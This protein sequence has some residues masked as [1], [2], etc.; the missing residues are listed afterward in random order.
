MNL[1]TLSHK[2]KYLYCL[3]LLYR[4]HYINTTTTC[5]IF[6]AVSWRCFNSKL[7]KTVW[8]IK[9]RAATQTP[10]ILN[11]FHIA[12]HIQEHTHT[13]TVCL[14]PP[15]QHTVCAVQAGDNVPEVF[16]GQ[17][18][19]SE[20]SDFRGKLQRAGADSLHVLHLP[21]IKEPRALWLSLLDV[22]SHSLP[23]DRLSV[24]LSA[25]ARSKRLP[26]YLFPLNFQFS[27]KTCS[28]LQNLA[29][30]LW[31]LVWKCKV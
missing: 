16:Q 1:S 5:R 22:R 7:I 13:N 15:P 21:S 24:C 30:Q 10:L 25:A 9:N 31:H 2:P 27:L 11:V 20:R 17:S 3:V 23:A 28:H 8:G 26:F 12:S 19:S 29:E 14:P 4:K 6:Q 18:V